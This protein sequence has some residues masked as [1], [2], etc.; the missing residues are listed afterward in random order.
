[1][2]SDNVQTYA[3]RDSSQPPLKT[4]NLKTSTMFGSSRRKEGI[5]LRTTKITSSM[6]AKPSQNTRLRF[7]TTS[8]DKTLSVKSNLR[9]VDFAR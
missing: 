5:R 2:R 6:K 4:Q 7:T 8:H 1:M 9:V 3:L